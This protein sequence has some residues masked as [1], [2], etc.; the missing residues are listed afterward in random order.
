VLASP[1]APGGV[2]EQIAELCSK[3]GLVFVAF[4]PISAAVR[5]RLKG[6]TGSPEAAQAVGAGSVGASLDPAGDAAA[7]VRKLHEVARDFQQW[8]GEQIDGHSVRRHRATCEVHGQGYRIK[9]HVMRFGQQATAAAT[10][11]AVQ[12]AYIQSLALIAAAAENNAREVTRLLDQGA[13]VGTKCDGVEWTSLHFAARLR[14]WEAAEVLVRRGADPNV[15]G[16]RGET[17]LFEAGPALAPASASLYPVCP[18]N[19]S[20]DPSFIPRGCSSTASTAGSG[21]IVVVVLYPPAW[22]LF[23]LFFFS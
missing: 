12:R 20:S 23:F 13:D 6:S 8:Y 22:A 3:L 7:N 18:F 16:S 2:G 15:R 19:H 5:E 21:G 14:C 10:A 1:L 11:T 4:E 9:K 17:P